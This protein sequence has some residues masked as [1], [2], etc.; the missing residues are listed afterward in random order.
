[1]ET[2]T[3][4]FQGILEERKNGGR[5]SEKEKPSVW[6]GGRAALLTR[7][8]RGEA[9]I[10]YRDFSVLNKER[11]SPPVWKVRAKREIEKEDRK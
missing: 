10:P 8:K 6:R 11:G 9:D 1:V 5:D 2:S 3:G 4:S 7:I